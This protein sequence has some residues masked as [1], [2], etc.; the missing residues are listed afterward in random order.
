MIDGADAVLEGR[1]EGSGTFR[2]SQVITKPYPVATSSSAQ[3]NAVRLRGD[4]PPI[5]DLVPIDLCLDL[6]YSNAHD[7]L[8][9]P[10]GLSPPPPGL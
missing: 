5:P 8:N 9:P 2:S 4:G 7:V 1:C 6:S 3:T 10:Q